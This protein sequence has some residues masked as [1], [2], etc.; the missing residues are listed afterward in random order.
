MKIDIHAWESHFEN[1]ADDLVR[2]FRE[3]QGRDFFRSHTERNWTPR[4]NVYETVG[5]FMVCAELPGMTPQEIDV[6]YGD[7]VLQLRGARAKP[8]PNE[9]SDADKQPDAVG[10]HVM[11]IDWGPFHRSI[12][13]GVDVD[14]DAIRASYRH[15][16]LWIVLPCKQGASKA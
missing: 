5:G 12:R 1:L 15:G 3:M 16:Y 7:G 2:M 11:E 9:N 8:Q 6:E 13:L 10:V 14:V 4:V